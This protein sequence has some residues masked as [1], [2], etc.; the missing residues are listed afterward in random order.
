MDQTSSQISTFFQSLQYCHTHPDAIL[1]YRASDM[2]LKVHSYASYLPEAKA[3]SQAGGHFYFGD[4]PS[5]QPKRGNGA[6]LNKSKI[7]KNVMSSA[8][9]A[10]C[11]ALFENTTDAIPLWNTLEEMGHPQPPTPIQVKRLTASGFTNKQSK[12]QRSK[13]MDMQFYWIQDK[14]V[15]Q[16]FN[17]YCRPGPTNYADYFTKHHAPS[18]HWRECSTYLH[19]LNQLSLVLRG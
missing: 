15:Q 14:V 1:R 9:K 18:Y 2:I 5:D 12:Q 6:L 11:G 10:E 8:A 19:R 3:R 17:I 7:M 16:Q 13:S 4:K